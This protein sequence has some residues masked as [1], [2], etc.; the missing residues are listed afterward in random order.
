LQILRC[1]GR[2]STVQGVNDWAAIARRA[3][4]WIVLMAM[5]LALALV[6]GRDSTGSASADDAGSTPAPRAAAAAKSPV[7]APLDRAIA[8]VLRHS[9]FVA[10]GGGHR[11]EI[12]L[13]F[14]DGPGPYTPKV[15]IALNRLN[16]KATFFVVGQQ[17]QTFRTAMM[18]AI[19]RGHVI[20]DHT[21]G[22]RR[23][24]TLSAADQYSEL[25]GPLQW[26]TQFGLPRPQLFRPPYGSY[27]ADT[28]DGL[29]RL[30][31]LMVLWSV[32]SKD[33]ERPGVQAI[34]DGVVAAAR[35]G[36]IVL[37]HDGGGDRTQTIA[38]IPKIV[39]R[40]RAKHYRFVT[41]PQLLRDDPPPAGRVAPQVRIDER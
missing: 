40:L 12:A 22:H 25:Q 13:T 18:A 17:E 28:L 15:L 7:G 2:R 9:A 6:S 34:V 26:L 10:R 20:G 29:R 30:G 32:D 41:V 38:A 39:R 36:A 33:Y 31:M 4:P 37:M 14:D 16:V 19:G 27:N 35:P 3:R 23:L 8:G 5:A 24:A 1:A 21:E 11:R